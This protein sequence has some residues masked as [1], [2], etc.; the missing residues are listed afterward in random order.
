MPI[1]P[2]CFLAA[3]GSNRS[4]TIDQ[5]PE[6]RTAPSEVIWRKKVTAAARGARGIRN[7]TAS[8]SRPPSTKAAGITRPGVKA[9][10]SREAARTAAIEKREETISI[11]GRAV[12]GKLERKRAS[13]VAFPATCPPITTRATAK[14]APAARS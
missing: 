9:A 12:I 13:L 4:L 6:I 10:I 3:W 5:N 11:V 8:W 1:R 14:A 2:I 7:Q